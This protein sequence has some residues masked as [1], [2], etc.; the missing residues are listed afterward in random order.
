M[1]AAQ[2]CQ[3]FMLQ[4]LTDNDKSDLSLPCI[5]LSNNCVNILGREHSIEELIS[6]G[7]NI[8]EGR[9][10]KRPE[11]NI[12]N[13]VVSRRH[14]SMVVH[15]TEEKPYAAVCVSFSSFKHQ[16]NCIGANDAL[17]P[18]T[19]IYYLHPTSS[20]NLAVCFLFIRS[21]LGWW[22][23]C[24]TGFM[25]PKWREVLEM[26]DDGKRLA[27]S[28]NCAPAIFEVVDHFASI[29]YIYTD[30]RAS[31]YLWVSV[32]HGTPYCR[33][34]LCVSKR[35]LHRVFVKPSISH[36]VLVA[37]K[38]NPSYWGYALR[39]MEALPSGLVLLNI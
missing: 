28:P 26:I 8:L 27:A 22:A 9:C 3:F 21:L 24:N 2:R 11:W 23:Q 37:N 35:R 1:A 10:Q 17:R 19:M 38:G 25:A 36:H 39:N 34:S 20:H 4:P 18:A 30:V 5:E 32:L 12:T 7:N 16:L 13:G 29:N 14:F 33:V 15:E 6:N 31:A